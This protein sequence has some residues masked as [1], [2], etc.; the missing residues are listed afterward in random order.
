MTDAGLQVA[1]VSGGAGGIGRAICKSLQREGYQVASLDREPSSAADLDLIVDLADS[2]SVDAALER[3]RGI[4][5]PVSAL[6]HAAATTE[7]ATTLAS[8]PEAF[9]RV[10]DV[11]VA[12]AVRLTQGLAADLIAARGAIVF[13]TSINAAFGAAGLSAYA[14]SKGGLE[15]LCRTLSMELAPEGVRVNAVAPAS[16]DTPMLQQSFELKPDP[17]GAKQ[18]NIGRHPLGR[19][20][21]PDDVAELVLFLVSG[22]SA[23]ITGAV[24]DIDG[25]ASNARR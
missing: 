5:G 11:N 23:W 10:Y 4:L 16:I 1:V 20:G 19:L 17:A 6:V 24:F 8:S 9:L 3:V 7:H 25:G 15:T 18:A 13:I 22:R 12:G 14:A 21:T 2:K